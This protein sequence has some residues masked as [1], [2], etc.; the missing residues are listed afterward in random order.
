MRL[1]ELHGMSVWTPEKE[2]LKPLRNYDATPPALVEAVLRNAQRNAT[3][4]GSALMFTAQLQP[5]GSFSEADLAAMRTNLSPQV[6]R[7]LRLWGARFVHI[8]RRNALD[9]AVSAVAGGVADSLQ[10]CA[11]RRQYLSRALTPSQ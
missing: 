5:W 2:L 11:C 6:A 10:S 7:L 9:V 8:T 4:M 1:L 3:R